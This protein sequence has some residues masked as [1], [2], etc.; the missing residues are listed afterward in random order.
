MR[1]YGK[2]PT[3]IK[4]MTLFNCR[5]SANRTLVRALLHQRKLEREIKKALS[6]I[7]EH[8]RAL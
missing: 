7:R 1:Y 3:Q 5:H 6:F 4:L 8:A 2:T